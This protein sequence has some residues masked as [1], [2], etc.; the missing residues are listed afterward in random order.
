MTFGLCHSIEI[1][2]SAMPQLAKDPVSLYAWILRDT[3][4]QENVSLFHTSDTNLSGW[5]TH[6]IICFQALFLFL[7]NCEYRRFI[8]ELLVAEYAM[9]RV[10]LTAVH[11]GR[12]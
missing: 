12:R 1:S 11:C 8:G 6:S 2:E 5:G 4:Y 7:L 9:S 10:I 3:A